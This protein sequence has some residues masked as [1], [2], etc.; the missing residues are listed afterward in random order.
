[1]KGGYPENTGEIITS[2]ILIRI[3]E[4]GDP[5]SNVD[6]TQEE[7]KRE[8]HITISGTIECNGEECDYP[9]VVRILPFVEIK[10]RRTPTRR[11]CVWCCNYQGSF[12]KR[13]LYNF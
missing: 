8:K 6:I 1:M 2:S 9:L 5:D 11:Y 7:L 12:E 10:C 13:R 4:S 3:N